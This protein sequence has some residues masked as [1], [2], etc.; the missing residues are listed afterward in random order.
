MSECYIQDFKGTLNL[1]E[2]QQNKKS[3]H[4][5]QWS[6]IHEPNQRKTFIHP[7]SNQI[8]KFSEINPGSLSQT[9]QNTK[10]VLLERVLDNDH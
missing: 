2:I 3:F 8:V 5:A 9:F 1:L 10:L 7:I 6:G 4:S